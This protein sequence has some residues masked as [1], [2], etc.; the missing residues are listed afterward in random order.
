[1]LRLPAGL[2]MSAS[3]PGRRAPACMPAASAEVAEV[4]RQAEPQIIFHRKTA[5][6]R[7]FPNESEPL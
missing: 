1:M 2:T 5:S 6:S 7:F 4:R 3:Q